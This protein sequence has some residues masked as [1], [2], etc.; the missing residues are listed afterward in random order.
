MGSELFVQRDVSLGTSRRGDAPQGSATKKQG[1]AVVRKSQ[2]KGAMK[3][4]SMGSAM[5]CHGAH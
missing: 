3:L 5:A 1:C 2:R 4:F